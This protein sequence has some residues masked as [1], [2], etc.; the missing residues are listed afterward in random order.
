MKTLTF[1]IGA[2]IAATSSSAW[3]DCYDAAAAYHRVNPWILRAIA[4]EESSFKPNAVG[5]NSNGSE[6][7]GVTQTNSVHFEELR[8]YGIG[9]NDLFDACTSVYVAG[10]LLQKKVKRHGN[11]WTAVGAYHSETPEK[12]DS[13]ARRIKRT[14]EAWTRAGYIKP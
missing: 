5:R 8:R 3:A 13:Y 6:D 11:T 10:W 9:R 12:R 1:L 4:A 14:I 2:Y 7:V